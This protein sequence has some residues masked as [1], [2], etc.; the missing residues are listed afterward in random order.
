ML[1]KFVDETGSNWDHWLPYLLFGYRDV[2]QASTG[3]SPFDLLYGHEVRD[4]LLHLRETR[5]YRKHCSSA[6][7]CSSDEGTLGADES[8]PTVIC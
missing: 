7:L 2:P 3:V 1:K 6:Y 4:P 5:N 8:W